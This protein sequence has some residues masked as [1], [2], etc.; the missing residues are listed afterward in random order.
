[1]HLLDSRFRGNDRCGVAGMTDE[2]D[3]GTMG[4][5]LLGMTDPEDGHARISV[6]RKVILSLRF[7][8][9]EIT[10]LILIFSV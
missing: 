10:Y 3:E 9:I 4:W 6:L 1:M 2:R 7:M 8:R 5:G